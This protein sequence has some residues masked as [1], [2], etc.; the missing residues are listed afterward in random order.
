MK[1]TLEQIIMQCDDTIEELEQ[2]YA[3]FVLMGGNRMKNMNK[4]LLDQIELVKKEKIMYQ[5]IQNELCKTG[6]ELNV[7]AGLT[8]IH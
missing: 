6:A 4:I 8:T 3:L 2:N 5:S 7:L 1:R